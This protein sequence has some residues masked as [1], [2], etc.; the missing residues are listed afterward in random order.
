MKKILEILIISAVLLTTA[1]VF[2][3]CKQFIDN[4]EEFLG[5]WS[6]EVVPTGFSIDK[7]YQISNDGA[8]CIPSDSPV[9][10]LTIK[11]HNPRKF[12]LITPTSMSSAADVQKIIN[13]PGL[14]TQP[15]Y[16]T[17][18]T[19]E[20]TPDKTALKLTYNS[21]FLKNHE[22]GTGNISPEIT[23]TSTDGRPFNKKFSLNLKADTAP[24][25]SS[26]ITIG[27]TANPIGGKYYYVII[28]KAEDMAETAGTGSSAGKRQKD[29]EELSVTGGDSA[30]IA[31]TSGNTAF[32]PSGR[33]LASTEVVHLSGDETSPAVPSWNPAL[34][35]DSWA[36]RYRTDTEVK[37]ARKNYTF[38]LI[39]EAGLKSSDIHVSTPAT[40]AEAAKL[41]YNSND[42]SI[43]AGNPSS[44]YLISTESSIT[45][46]AKTETTGATIRGTLF[47]KESSTWRFLN[48]IDSSSNTEVD[49]MLTAPSGIGSEIEYQISLTVKEEGF[50]DSDTKVFYVKVRKGTVL[51]INSTDSGAW[52]TLKTEVERSSGGPDI[53]KITG[54]IKA[55]SG[56]NNQINVSRTV[57]IMGSNKNTDILD[58]DNETFIFNMGLQGV[59]T[60]EKLT[61]Q[62]GKNTDSSRGGG[63]IYCAGGELTT[64]DI[65]IKDCTA[66]KN[67]GGIY[68]HNHGN[69]ILI[70]TEIKGCTAAADGGGVYVGENGTFKM[71]G[72]TIKN[73]TSILG[74]GVYVQGSTGYLISDG[75][76][77]M[78]GEAC[79]GEW[80]NGT[81]QDGND[82]Y[83]DEGSGSLAH[84]KIDKG[85]PI[86]KSKAA[87]ITPE[88]YSAGE[89]VL[90]M[91]G[92]STDV[93]AYNDRFT[94]TPEDS[95]SGN[96]QT[97]S[98]D[99]NGQLTRYTKVRYDQLEAFLTSPQASSTAI[100]RIEITGEI[101]QNHFDGSSSGSGELN[102]RI[103]KAGSK[104]LAL[105]LPAGISDVTSMENCFAGCGNLVSLENI[106]SGVTN[107]KNCFL[108]C[109]GL[110][111]AP[112]IPD[113]VM[114]M[115]GC[116]RGCNKLIT[117]PTIPDSVKNMKECFLNCTGLT[118]IPGISNS[119]TDM[120]SCFR[121][122]KELTTGPDIPSSVTNMNN[123]FLNC[124]KLKGVKINRDYYGCN[125]ADAFHGCSGLNAGGIKVPS[126]YLQNY[127][128]NAG[129]MGT[130]ANKFSAITP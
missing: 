51:E 105:K 12:S 81:L 48:D 116:F 4:P 6:S 10:T 15:A 128:D 56:P 42:I 102:K 18:Y 40:K 46:K 103:K 64:D 36:L 39:D 58:A 92:G 124:I 122:C 14:L 30:A 68:V 32:E 101:P 23:L 5:Y 17:D 118:T 41:S 69:I 89:T 100:N 85:K 88:S 79:V 94:V 87:C 120:E 3:S 11:L 27:K 78:G 22:W 26:S 111:T 66:T 9:T 113:G 20:Q 57:K 62:K 8:L 49:I 2:T 71:H 70:D 129:T 115:E 55:P 130:S 63:A 54:K 31:F 107:M 44:P 99:D 119:V 91:L 80:G 83:L 108:N 21:A 95:G 74:K 59:L 98:I 76:F 125:F 38:T 84:I 29:I 114:N 110:T 25:L 24:K 35:N 7:P 97:W 121:G 72:G 13:F 93:G 34:N 16:N 104:K 52:T 75:E 50:A 112:S 123:C 47:K 65:I 82:V 45:V 86:T 77:I 53:I 19:L 109:T 33:L 43:Q 61:L 126:I 117:A 1:I 73:N 96:T 127:K 106:P 60:L 28:L 67:G 37:T 90:M